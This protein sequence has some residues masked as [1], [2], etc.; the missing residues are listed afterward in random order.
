M[1]DL[2]AIQELENILQGRVTEIESITQ[3]PYGF[4]GYVKDER[5][6]IRE[7]V[8][9]DAFWGNLERVIEPIK[10][11]RGLE[12]LELT[13]ANIQDISPL[14]EFTRLRYLDLY[15]NNIDDISI[16][17]N[18]NNLES[19]ELMDNRIKDITPLKSLYGLTFLSLALNYINNISSLKDCR[20]LKTLILVGNSIEDIYNEPRK[21]DHRL[22]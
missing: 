3:N 15:N 13:T 11:L 16:L 18:F 14:K 10:K 4:S 20:E 2:Y 1:S 6:Y 9:A 7:L 21:L 19:L 5:G 22:R 8:L 17:E 12:K